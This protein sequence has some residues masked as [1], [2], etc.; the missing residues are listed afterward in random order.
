MREGHSKHK[1]RDHKRKDFQHR[2][3]VK[4]LYRASELQRNDGSLLELP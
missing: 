4:L 2:E 1:K 3:K